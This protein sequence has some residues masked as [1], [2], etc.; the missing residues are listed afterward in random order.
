MPDRSGAVLNQPPDAAQVAAVVEPLLEWS[1]KHLRDLPWRRTRDPWHVLVSEVMLQ[2]TQVSRV[3]PKWHEFI[4]RFPTPASCA[5]AS[6]GDIIAMW[7]G[8]GFNRRAVNLW[9]A[10]GEIVERF[11]G[12]VPCDVAQLQS[13]SGIGPY[14]ARAV[15]VFA[16]E[17]Q[18]GV[19]DTNVG[20][21]LARWSG[22]PFRAGAAQGLADALVPVDAWR[23][24]QTLFD[25][26]NAQCTK[27]EPDCG[28]CCLRNVC[29]YR[30]IGEDPA[31]GSAG[32]S[33][34]QGRFEGS[35]RQV[36]GRV[37]DAL[38]HGPVALD[39]LTSLGRPGAD[40]GEIDEIVAALSDEG[41]VTF[42]GKTLRLP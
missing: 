30:G 39:E 10:A 7:A 18:V 38:R 33:K 23:W 3:E 1:T 14:T 4:A 29:A 22:H 9:R 27:R 42:I 17:Q 28:S 19:V 15:A 20:R 35:V 24:N 2:Q 31:A 5:A 6:A 37:L 26:A 16:F 11:D 21:L 34:P 13:L 12:C 25:F 36:R 40:P 8:L 41:L 32:V